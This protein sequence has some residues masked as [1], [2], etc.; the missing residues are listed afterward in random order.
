MKN[1]IIYKILATTIF[2]SVFH[3]L[4]ACVY[5]YTTT[6][7]DVSWLFDLSSGSYPYK[8]YIVSTNLFIVFAGVSASVFVNIQIIQKKTTEE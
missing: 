5:H 2:L 8:R 3:F 7:S 1:K 6:P 4:L